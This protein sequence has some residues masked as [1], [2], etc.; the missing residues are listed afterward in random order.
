MIRNLKR[1]GKILFI[2]LGCIFVLLILAAVYHHALLYS[3]ASRIV[4]IGTKIDIDGFNMNVYA[5]GIKKTEK[6]GTIVLLSGS[7]VTAPVYDYKI[8]Y[9]KLSPDYRIAVVEKFGYGYSDVSGKSRDVATMVE[10]NRQAL[11][12]AGE[13]PP[14]ILMPHSMSALEA[15]YWAVAYPDEISAVI[16]LDMAV[17]DYYS[18][19]NSNLGNITLMKTGVFFG[20]HRIPLFNP[21]SELGLSGQEIQQ[22]KL[23][24]Y[25]NSLNGDVYEECRT[26]LQNAETVQKMGYPDLPM[27][28]FTTNYGGGPDSE[29]WITAQDHFVAQSPLYTQIKLDCGH[30]LHYYE[31]DLIADRIRVF[32]EAFKE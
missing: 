1:V 21:V 9:S 19:S 13:N 2:A 27:L 6:D 29:E 24:S 8:L 14:Y 10:E 12:L 32:L 20:A 26:V 15:I 17:P 16:G 4:P 25:R 23:L 28:M 22:H 31:S 30:N 18:E 7:G 11:Q 5:E 3:E